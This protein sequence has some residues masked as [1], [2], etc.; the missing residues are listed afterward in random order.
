MNKR[1]LAPLCALGL[2]MLLLLPLAGSAEETPSAS[3]EMAVISLED[4][5]RIVEASK[6]DV[7]VVDIWA[8]WCISCIERLPV[9][10]RCSSAIRS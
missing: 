3:T 9:I 7:L 8:S 5:P 1:L 4:W 2:L 6:P 10:H